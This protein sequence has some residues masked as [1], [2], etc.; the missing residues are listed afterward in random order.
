M[1]SGCNKRH[2]GWSKEEIDQDLAY[3]RGSHGS[4]EFY[5]GFYGGFYEDDGDSADGES[6][7]GE[8]LPVR[9]VGGS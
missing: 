9:G 2:A 1:Q 6:D 8:D 4:G 7:D 5:R 3:G